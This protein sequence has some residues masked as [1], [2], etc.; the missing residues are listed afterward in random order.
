MEMSGTD[1]LDQSF[2]LSMF[3]AY[4]NWL[5]DQDPAYPEFMYWWQFSLEMLGSTVSDVGTVCPGHDASYES[6]YASGYIGFTSS[7]LE[8]F[9]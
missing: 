1:P 2:T 5:M 7:L 9:S 4:N 6:A 3:T 8:S